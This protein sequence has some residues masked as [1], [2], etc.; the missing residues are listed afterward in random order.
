MKTVKV[1][2]TGSVQGVMF[3]NF[4]KEIAEQLNIKGFTRNLE[5]GRVECV[6]EGRDENINQMI[7]K[8]KIGPRHSEIKNIRVENLKHQGFKDFRVIRM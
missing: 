5:D 6:L 2:I 1:F 3:R 7:E 4:I 8:C